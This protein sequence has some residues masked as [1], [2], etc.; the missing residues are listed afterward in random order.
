[1]M[2]ARP[3]M[4]CSACHTIYHLTQNQRRVRLIE[5]NRRTLRVCG[6]QG[7]CRQTAHSLAIVAWRTT[8]YTVCTRGTMWKKKCKKALQINP[9]RSI[10][11]IRMN[12]VMHMCGY[13]I[14]GSNFKTGIKVRKA[15]HTDLG[16]GINTGCLTF[17][18]IFMSKV[19]SK[20]M[21][22]LRSMPKKGKWMAAILQCSKHHCTKD[23]SWEF[24]DSWWA[25]I[26]HRC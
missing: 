21:R 9:R 18:R 3:E 22:L 23:F 5:K 20:S 16:R 25:S 7:N 11:T 26:S 14:R 19:L 2:L 12:H 10:L 6:V 17:A 13:V 24:H 8:V 1:M 4:T 15:K